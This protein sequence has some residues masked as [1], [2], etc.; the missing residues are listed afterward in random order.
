MEQAFLDVLN[1]HPGILHKVCRLYGA[2][3]EQQQD[4]YQEIVFQLWKAFPGF[5]HQALPSTWMYRIALNTAITFNRQQRQRMQPLPLSA[6]EF[7]IPDFAW[8]TGEDDQV[9][10]LYGAIE[11]LSAIEK[12]L[13]MLYLEDKRYEEMATILGISPTHVGVKLNRIKIKLRMIVS[14]QPL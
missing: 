4:L 3:L 2:D 9:N 12:A 1:A 13:I 11:Q 5:R 6:D 8:Q 14:N 10:Q 7:T